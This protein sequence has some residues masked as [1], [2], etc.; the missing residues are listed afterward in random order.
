[1]KSNHSPTIERLK[2]KIWKLESRYENSRAQKSPNPYYYCVGCGIH[3]P[4]LSVRMGLHFKNCQ[5]QGLEKEIEY[6]KK[7]LKEEEIKNV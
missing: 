4:Q 2:N 1:M 6:Y 7:L 5:Y 3:D